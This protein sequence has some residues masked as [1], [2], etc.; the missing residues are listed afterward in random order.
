MVTPPAGPGLLALALLVVLFLAYHLLER[1]SGAPDVGPS[2]APG[3]Q[4]EEPTPAE[5][6]E[7]ERE[8]EELE[9]EGE[10]GYGREMPRAPEPENGEPAG[11]EP[12]EPET[13]PQD[14]TGATIP[15]R[16]GISVHPSHRKANGAAGAAGAAGSGAAA[17]HELAE[18]GR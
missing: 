8:E 14:G 7:L 3:P 18:A 1:E 10:P 6:E 2:P 16:E 17:E 15:P 11:E 13:T 4:P 5:R 9:A 12:A